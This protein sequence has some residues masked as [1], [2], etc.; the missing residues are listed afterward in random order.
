VPGVWTQRA[1]GASR[2]PVG[3][4]GASLPAS[5]GLLGFEL[6]DSLG[7]RQEQGGAA[8]AWGT[9]EAEGESVHEHENLGL[10]LQILLKKGQPAENHRPGRSLPARSGH[11]A[12]RPPGTGLGR[13]FISPDTPG[14][15][16]SATGW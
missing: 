7:L 14:R 9:R 8:Q 11:S 10:N 16:L 15:V 1:A 4:V 5:L 2:S 13:L 3:L 6:S 12:R